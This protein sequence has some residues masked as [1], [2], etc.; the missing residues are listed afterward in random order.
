MTARY[1]WTLDDIRSADKRL[2]S[3]AYEAIM[4]AADSPVGW[5]YDVWATRNS[6]SSLISPNC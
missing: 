3:R 1:Q 5:A 6:A 2:Q 4:A